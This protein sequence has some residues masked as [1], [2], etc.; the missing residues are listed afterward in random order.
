MVADSEAEGADYCDNVGM[1]LKNISDLV[2]GFGP[3]VSFFSLYMVVKSLKVSYS[4][5]GISY[6]RHFI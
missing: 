1:I 4:W 3:Q 2:P 6:T 5:L